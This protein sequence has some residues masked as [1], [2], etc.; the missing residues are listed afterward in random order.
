MQEKPALNKNAEKGR[1]RPLGEG[2]MYA[3]ICLTN[4]LFE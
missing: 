2:D 3:H 4:L 1:K